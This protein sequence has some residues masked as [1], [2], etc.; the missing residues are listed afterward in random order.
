MT[1]GTPIV[2]KDTYK[3]LHEHAELDPNLK[4]FVCKEKRTL[5]LSCTV[6]RSIHNKAFGDAGIAA[7]SGKTIEVVDLACLACNPGQE[8][9]DNG[10]PVYLEDLMYVDGTP[11][12]DFE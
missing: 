11:V 5:V 12:S 3:W 10:T 7:G 8:P 6:V 4:K 1:N 9:P 2:T